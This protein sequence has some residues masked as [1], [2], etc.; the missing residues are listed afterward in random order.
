MRTRTIITA[1]IIVAGVGAGALYASKLMRQ[2]IEFEAP[3]PVIVEDVADSIG[4]P[5]PSFVEAPI[6]YDLTPAL[7]KMEAAVPKHFGDLT[8]RLE[9]PTN[10]RLH[11]AFAADRA[12]FQVSIEGQNVRISTTIEYEGRGWYKPPIGPEVSAACGTGGVPRPRVRATLSSQVKL[13][14]DWQLRTRTAIARLEP[15]SDDPRDRC[16]VTVFRVDVTERVVAATRSALEKQ[17][18]TLDANIA[19]IDTRARFVS[20]GKKGQSPACERL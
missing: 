14:A 9:S 4:A 6:L 19:R 17:L 16:K 3:P 11:F 13:T 7:S 15:F 1:V 10:K 5:P 20:S 2:P 8:Q 18:A 12:P